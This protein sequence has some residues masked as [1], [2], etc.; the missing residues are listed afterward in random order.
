MTIRKIGNVLYFGRKRRRGFILDNFK[1][2]PMKFLNFHQNPHENEISLVKRGVLH[3]TSNRWVTSVTKL[4]IRPKVKYFL[5][6][7]TGLTLK[8]G[9]TQKKSSWFRFF[10][11]L[12]QNLYFHTSHI[13]HWDKISQNLAHLEANSHKI[14]KSHRI[15][16]PSYNTFYEEINISHTFLFL[17]QASY[18]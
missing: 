8:K 3:L 2:N 5:F 10:F 6:P 18:I 13:S 1:Q 7:L 12:H 11:F 16:R 15:I 17:S 4:T 14:I 9:P